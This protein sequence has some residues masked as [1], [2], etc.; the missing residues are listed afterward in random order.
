[1]RIGLVLLLMLAAC[2]RNQVAESNQA[3]I[4][5]RANALEKAADASVDESIAQMTSESVAESVE[6]TTSSQ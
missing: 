3:A 1:M 4:I 2:N 5:E 6:N